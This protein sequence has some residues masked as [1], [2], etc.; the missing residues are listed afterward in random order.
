MALDG[1]TLYKIK[2]E[3]QEVLTGGW[4][5]KIY[6][7]R[8]NLLVVNI[9][10]AGKYKLL[11]SCD[12]DFRVQLTN[13]NFNHPQTPSPFA[14][15]L[16]K[17]LSGG[18]IARIVQ[19]GIDRVL[20]IVVNKKPEV[21]DE[22]AAMVEKEL[23]VELTGRSSNVIL[24]QGDQI[25]GVLNENKHRE[26]P[27]QIGRRYT[28]PPGGDKLKPFNLQRE[29]FQ[30]FF[31]SMDENPIWRR[32]MN[33]VEGIGPTIAKEIP[34]RT[35]IP[36]DK[37]H[38]TDSDLGNLWTETSELF[39]QLQDPGGS[40]IVYQEDGL[41]TEFSSI[42]LVLYQDNQKL[43][44]DSWQKALDYFYKEK[45]IGYSTS[46]LDQELE[47]VIEDELN[48]IKGALKNVKE[49]LKETEEREKYK[50]AGDLILANLNQI[51][52]KAKRVQV[53]DF[54]N[55]GKTRTIN[56]DPSISP[57][58][59]AQKY[60]EKYK[61]LKRGRTKLKNRQRSL[62]KELKFI[63][64]RKDELDEADTK[65]ELV[66]LERT[67]TERGYIEEESEETTQDRS[68]PKEYWVKGYKIMVGRNA[69][70]NDKLV[71]TASR[72]DIWFHVRNYA[73]AHVIVVTD[74]RPDMVPEEVI[75]KAAQLAAYNSKARASSKVMVS[76]T[77][78]KYVNKPKGAK[79]GLVRIT[80]EKTVAV[81]PREVA[82]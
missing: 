8:E 43:T 34:T 39:T 9:W 30:A 22:Q 51:R 38:L 56:L 67:L 80:H 76:F 11:I 52:P 21:E 12:N 77:Q 40:P 5:R 19:E 73:G 31:D 70:Q 6:Q 74:G 20:R 37:L 32:L 71:R 55:E 48:R 61:K 27:L 66:S 3:L 1:V 7:P 13:L 53:E 2:R 57:E 17:H 49:Q 4:V 14:M 50:Q 18:K 16:R 47:D 68:K 35:Q 15:L 72:D 24:V 25:L 81:N 42:P 65:E 82:T 59:N 33:N 60:Y 26:P 46:D 69:R 58:D 10:S 62:N 54:Y 63:S 79:P 78:A 45:E 36:P 44:F 75:E 64:E 29:Q 23:V 41:P 28:L